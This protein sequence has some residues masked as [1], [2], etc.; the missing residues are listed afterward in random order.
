MKRNLVKRYQRHLWGGFVGGKLDIMKVDAGFGGWGK[1]FFD[2][3]A[4]FKSKAE[5]RCHY[6]DVRPVSIKELAR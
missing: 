5:A 3:P 2:T 4:I 6:A 1:N